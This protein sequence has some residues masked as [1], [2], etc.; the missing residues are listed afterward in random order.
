MKLM[1][2]V[3]QGRYAAGTVKKHYDGDL[4]SFCKLYCPKNWQVELKNA[5][6]FMAKLGWKK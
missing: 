5:K 1:N 6:W 4:Q 2:A 3:L